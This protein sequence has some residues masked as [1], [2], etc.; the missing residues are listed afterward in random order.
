VRLAVALHLALF[1]A[2]AVRGRSRVGSYA[3][4]EAGALAL[5]TALLCGPLVHKAHL[6]WSALAFA[7]L[8]SR[9][10]SATERGQWLRRALPVALAALLIGAT[11]P[12]LFGSDLAR[13]VVA[14]SGLFLGIE[15]LWW[16]L[17]VAHWRR[18]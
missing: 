13:A 9:V 6:C 4:A 17:L 5:C 8:L 18:A 14:G 2:A 1:A 7:V 16:A 15:C 11:T 10:A 3:V 12:L